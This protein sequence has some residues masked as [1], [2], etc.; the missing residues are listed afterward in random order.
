MISKKP[1]VNVIFGVLGLLI[2]GL[3]FIVSQLITAI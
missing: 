2:A 3:Y 1:M